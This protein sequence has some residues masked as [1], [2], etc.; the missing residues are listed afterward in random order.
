MAHTNKF[1]GLIIAFAATMVLSG[2][3]STTDTKAVSLANLASSAKITVTA[4]DFY[5]HYAPNTGSTATLAGSISFNDASISSVDY[6]IRNG[7]TVLASGT[8]SEGPI[9]ITFDLALGKY[10]LTLVV[11][12]DQG[13]TFSDAFYVDL[14]NH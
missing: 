3:G 8:L 4:N 13:N 11:S 10:N 12:D 1:L 9:N 6:E 14:H 7:A 2:C 5:N